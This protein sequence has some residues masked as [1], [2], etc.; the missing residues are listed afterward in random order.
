[1]SDKLATLRA[2]LAAM[3]ATADSPGTLDAEAERI[4]RAERQTEGG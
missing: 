2:T 3:G 1:M 4:A